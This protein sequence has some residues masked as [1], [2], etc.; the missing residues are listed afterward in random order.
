MNKCTVQFKWTQKVVGADEVKK[1]GSSLIM[2]GVKWQYKG[3]E[4]DSTEDLR[5]RHG[6][7]RAQLAAY[8]TNWK[9]GAN[10]REDLEVNWPMIA[11]VENVTPISF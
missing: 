9:G 6:M 11:Y 7:V 2:Q 1:T 4:L 10:E 5:Q 3:F 8:R